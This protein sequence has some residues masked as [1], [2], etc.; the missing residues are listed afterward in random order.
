MIKEYTVVWHGRGV[1]VSAD[2]VRVEAHLE[3]AGYEACL[4]YAS[5]YEEE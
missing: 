5:E 2:T 4:T 3:D 1:L